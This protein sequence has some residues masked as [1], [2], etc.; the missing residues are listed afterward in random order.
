V[1]SI[2]LASK[3][4]AGNVST[5]GSRTFTIRRVPS[6]TITLAP[7]TPDGENDWYVAPVR[8]TV[9]G[10]SSQGGPVAEIRCVLDPPTAPASFA[11]LPAGCPFAGTGALVGAD[12]EH[13]VYAA[14]RDASN[15]VSPVRSSSF[16]LDATAPDLT[17]DATGPV[18]FTI[19]AT[20]GELT[21]LVD[22]STSGPETENVSVTLTAG[23]L[24][25]L[26]QRTATVSGTDLAGN[27]GSVDCAYV[28]GYDLEIVSPTPGAAFPLGATIPV[29]YQLSDANGVPIPDSTAALLAGGKRTPC[30]IDAFLDGAIQRG[31]PTYSTATKRFTSSVK[32]PKRRSFAGLHEAAIQVRSPDQSGMILNYEFVVVEVR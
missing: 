15:A 27:E 30:F 8:V 28:V 24:D 22:D 5:L 16:R 14:S 11:N 17:C 23:D 26:G 9:T 21:A 20:D 3:D 6:A 2:W 12:G 32:T 31:C 10:Q 19:G 18:R 29:V 7:G 4:P 25:S 1:H 13:T